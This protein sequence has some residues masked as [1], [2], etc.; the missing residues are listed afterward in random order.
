MNDNPIG[1]E[2]V[3]AMVSQL[4]PEDQLR[5]VAQIGQRLGATLSQSN[6]AQVGPPAA[7]VL[8]AARDEPHVT[9]EDVDELDRM[10]AGGRLPVQP[11]GVFDSE[12]R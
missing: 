3:A 4:P 1:L 11:G 7:A 6:A 5:L 12:D 2:G 8:R 10:I 9:K